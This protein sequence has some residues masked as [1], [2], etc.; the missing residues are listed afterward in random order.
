MTTELQQY[1]SIVWEP[2]D[3]IEIRPLQPWQGQRKWTHVADLAQHAERMM[4]ENE[5]GANIFAGIMPRNKFGF[6]DP[7]KINRKGEKGAWVGGES[8][9]VDGGRV[10]WADFDHCEAEAAIEITGKLKMPIPSMAV[11]TGHGAHLFWRLKDWTEKPV[12][13][14]LVSGLISFLLEKPESRPHIDKS[15]KDPARIL[16]LPGFVNHKPPAAKAR[17]VYADTELRYAPEDFAVFMPKE[18]APAPVSRSPIPQSGGGDKMERARRYLS[19][20]EG[21][22]PGGRTNTAFRAACVMVNDI[23]L[24]EAEALPILEGW[25]VGANSPTIAQDYGSDEIR[26]IIANAAKYAKKSPGCLNAPKAPSSDSPIVDGV[27]L[28]GILSRKQE[29]PVEA[30][31][32]QFLQVPGFMAEVMEF[33]NNTAPKPQPV[34][35]LAGA[36]VLQAVLCAR[37]LTDEAGTRPNLYVCGV[38]NSGAGKDHA[39]QLNKRI[40]LEAG[41]SQLQA[42]GIKSGSGLVNALVIQPGLLFQ[43][44]EYGRF[45]KTANNQGKNPHTYEIISK[46]L[47]LYSS[48]GGVYESDRYADK[49]A[50]GKQVK[51]PHAILYGTT[52]PR[53]LYDGLSEESVTDGFLSRTLIFDVDGHN[54]IRRRVKTA[55]VP[56]LIIERARW[57]G[58]FTPPGSGNMNP[59]AHVAP[60]SGEADAIAQAFIETEHREQEALKDSPLATLWTRTAQNADKLALIY[61]ASK[62]P[63]SPVI[64]SEAARWGYG[65]AE[66]L[67]RRMVSIIGDNVADNPFHAE[68]LKVRRIFNRCGGELSRRDMLR[69]SKLKA[70][71]LD[72]VISNMVETDEVH[73]ITEET[74]GRYK[75]IYK[76]IG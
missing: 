40:L 6:Y 1:A 35:A 25:D 39:R 51:D 33:N 42:E 28:S 60:I 10:I 43:I 67:T 9:D 30:F 32:E 49:D 64:D 55:P 58:D 63:E 11:A 19:M 54:P 22:A 27:D 65:L 34:L 56:A 8:E 16:R 48:S 37:K 13:Q 62:A 72:E 70:R 4:S 41:L 15:A 38:A 71:D 14:E 61:A 26:K 47:G 53:S 31:P 74:P 68:R 24:S 44:D 46:L 66:W 17:I 12:I 45:I 76:L 50:G 5:R 23:G 21:C 20:M 52:V 7:E 2:D 69:K 75:T 73:V 29:A 36:I 18:A 57:W 3:L 59:E